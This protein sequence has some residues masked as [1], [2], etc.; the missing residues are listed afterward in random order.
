MQLEKQAMIKFYVQKFMDIWYYS[1]V[2]L[3]GLETA[4]AS[5]LKNNFVLNYYNFDE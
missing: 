1:F 4:T 2:G 3:G 5:S